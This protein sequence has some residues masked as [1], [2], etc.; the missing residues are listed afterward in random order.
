MSKVTQAFCSH[1]DGMGGQYGSCDACVER[2][3]TERDQ[4]AEVLK[5]V[6][7]ERG[8]NPALVKLEKTL[9]QARHQLRNE[10]IAA[11]YAAQLGGSRGDT[12]VR[13][14]E[15]LDNALRLLRGLI[16]EPPAEPG[17]KPA[18]AACRVCSAAAGSACNAGHHGA[19]WCYHEVCGRLMRGAICD[20]CGKQ[21]PMAEV[22]LMPEPLPVPRRT[23]A[24]ASW[25]Q[26]CG[27]RVGDLCAWDCPAR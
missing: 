23:N 18:E 14:R 4:L 26:H 20:H 25:C 27:A 13:A 24:Y 9:A 8:L 15:H 3:L 22:M 6:S 5:D 16:R 1:G 19:A 17:P 7:E 10:A 12:T 21:P 11:L 2:L